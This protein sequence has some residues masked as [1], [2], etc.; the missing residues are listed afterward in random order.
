MNRAMFFASDGKKMTL[1]INSA[2]NADTGKYQYLPPENNQLA[3]WWA[4]ARA[5]LINHKLKVIITL[6]ILLVLL[7]F[8]GL[9]LFYL[10]SHSTTTANSFPDSHLLPIKP[11]HKE[12]GLI[13]DNAAAF[14]RFLI[15]TRFALQSPAGEMITSAIEVNNCSMALTVPNTQINLPLKAQCII[16]P[17]NITSNSDDDDDSSMTFWRLGLLSRSRVHG[18]PVPKLG[19]QLLFFLF[20][21]LFCL[22]TGDASS[23]SVPYLSVGVCEKAIL[24]QQFVI[25]VEAVSVKKWRVYFSIR[26]LKHPNEC[27]ELQKDIKLKEHL[28]FVMK[29]CIAGQA[30]QYFFLS[31][32]NYSIAIADYQ[33]QKKNTVEAAAASIAN[34]NAQ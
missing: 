17:S 15:K 2:Y 27:I 5:L 13:Y 18:Q 34:G 26:S 3:S 10:L 19:F 29:P 6:I 31:G 24:D 14:Y 9:L 8:L 20:S 21:S 4:R 32:V 23:S 1:Y 11:D 12:D 30:S 28:V 25:T 16:S 33:Q 22:T 7:F